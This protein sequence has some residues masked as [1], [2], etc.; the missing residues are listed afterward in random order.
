MLVC[1]Q[2]PDYQSLWNLHA[3]RRSGFLQKHVIVYALLGDSI[4]PSG[5]DELVS[6]STPSLLKCSSVDSIGK[7]SSLWV[8]VCSH[9][10]TEPIRNRTGGWL[11][12]ENHGNNCATVLA[13][14][15]SF[16]PNP[17]PCF[18]PCL[19]QL[20]CL[21][22]SNDPGLVKKKKNPRLGLKNQILQM[23]GWYYELH[24]THSVIILTLL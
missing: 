11:L 18:W 4:K 9:S 21:I 1:A 17:H 14:T 13:T 5:A 23:Y 10:Q 2:V 7:Q 16:F 24:A 12:K 8:E 6:A 20:D 3:Y 15:T 19:S 22:P